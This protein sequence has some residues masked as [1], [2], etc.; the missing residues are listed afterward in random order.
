MGNVAIGE[1]AIIA[2]CRY[3]FGYPITPQNEISEYMSRRIPAHGGAFIQSES[4]LAAINMVLGAAAGGGR[5]MTTSSS[6]GISLMQEGISYIAGMEIPCVIANVVRGGPGL[7]GIG[8]AQS[9]YF[10]AVKGGGH[11]DYHTIVLAPYNVQEMLDFTILSF[12]LADKYRIPVMI[13]TDGLL[14]QTMETVEVPLNYQPKRYKKD[15]VMDGCKGRAP[16]RLRSLFLDPEDLEDHNHRLF[17]KYRIIEQKECLVDC[18]QTRGALDILLVAYGTSARICKAVVEMGR[19]QGLRLGLFRPITLYPF[20]EQTLR[21]MASRARAVMVVELSMGQMLEDIRRIIG[22]RTPVF[23]KGRTG[24][25]VFSPEEI[26]E[27]VGKTAKKIM[28]KTKG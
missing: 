19:K 10:Q 2:G 23:F 15:W 11:G 16:R 9:D 26:F 24:G 13:L 5:A 22:D 21:D 1:G 20:D 12:D 3:Y 4:E 27:E 14:G 25:M 17:A 6:P 7:G 8:P 28:R 18:F